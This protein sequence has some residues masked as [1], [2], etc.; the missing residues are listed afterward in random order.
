MKPSRIVKMLMVVMLAFP[1]SSLLVS[2]HELAHAETAED[3]PPVIQP[4]GSVNGKKVLFDNTHGETAGAADWVIDG[5]FSDF[6]NG[7]AKKGYEVKELRK[8]SPITYDDLKNY[9]VFV[10]GEANIPFKASEQEA[11]LHYVQNGGSVFFIA[12]HYNSDRN[13]NRW[14]AEEVYNG[15]R[16]G[17]F[18]DPTKGM[19]TEEAQSPAMQGVSSSDWLAEH[20]GVRFRYNALGDIT[21][22]ETIVSPSD[23]FG[24]TSGV[25]SVEMHSGSTI[26]IL[27]PKKAKGL[28][29][30]PKNPPAWGPA[31]DQGV[32][33]NGGVAEGAFAAIAKVGKGKAAFIGDSSPVEDATPKYVREDTGEKK[34]TYDGFSKEGD[35]A[36]FLLNTMEWLAKQEDYTS[37]DG[38]VPLSEKTKLHDFEV[39]ENSTEPEKEPWTTPVAGYKWWDPSTF[40]AGAYGSD[41]EAPSQ[42]AYSFQHQATLPNHQEFQL[43]LNV[44]DLSPGQTL[45]NLKVGIYKAGGQQLAKFKVGDGD[46]P[47][48]YGYSAPFTITADN[49]GVGHKDLTVMLDPAYSGEANLR[50]K[51]DGTNA[52][53]EDVTIADVA[54]EPLPPGEN[55]SLPELMPIAKARA[56]QDGG[57]VTVE[58]VV[59][60]TPGIWGGQG[61]YL[62]DAS[63][64]V[65]V[66]QSKESN[67]KIGDKVKISAKKTTYNGEVELSDLIQFTPEG[68][69]EVPKPQV[70]SEVSDSNQGELVTL[71][72]IKVKNISDP[73]SYGTFKFDAVN[74][75]HTTR[76]RIDSRSGLDYTDFTKKYKRN[77]TLTLTGVASIF[78]GTYELKPRSESDIAEANVNHPTDV[79]Q[80]LEV[81]WNKLWQLLHFHV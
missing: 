12:D 55:E 36:T 58:G 24:I 2:R 77:A 75:K 59:T 81:I 5:A 76:V 48:S 6:G 73:D 65:Y 33:D 3:P 54:A 18:A 61:F 39:P 56:E 10:L 44:K 7:L 9:D 17:A 25:N 35:D 78:K 14:D 15:Y 26:A 16:R 37:F 8:T 64:G 1:L 57:S 47:V 51:V 21:S 60:T 68:T 50:L 23:D 27:D 79:K 49:Q 46:Y 11:I 30:L 45:S 62:Q 22:G 66:Y 31:V 29:Y 71:E 52:V 43:R 74:G 63:G 34:T 69:A 20:F 70:V 32:Y 19:S 40:A 67:L 41:K 13:L 42:P 80:W 53:T 72:D 4:V 28:I 38:K